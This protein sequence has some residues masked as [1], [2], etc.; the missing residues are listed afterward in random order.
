M[1]WNVFKSMPEQEG[2]LEVKDNALWTSF[3]RAACAFHTMRCSLG[4]SKTMSQHLCLSVGHTPN[5][6]LSAILHSCW[7]LQDRLRKPRR[8]N[9]CCKCRRMILT[10]HHTCR[11]DTASYMPRPTG[12]GV[13]SAHAFFEVCVSALRRRRLTITSLDSETEHT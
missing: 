11:Q 6:L 10:N 13:P 4:S 7:S 2:L 9:R 3:G 5:V 8:Q 12:N 1:K